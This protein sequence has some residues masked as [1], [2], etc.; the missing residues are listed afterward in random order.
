MELIA[1]DFEL[2]DCQSPIIGT[3]GTFD[4][5]H[6]GHQAILNRLVEA[7]QEMQ[8]KSLVI[9]FSPHPLQ[10]VRPDKAPKLLT[11]NGEKESVIAQCGIDY[12]LILPFDREMAQLGPEEFVRTV[13]I[14][15]CNMVKMIIG[16]D[17]GFGRNRSGHVDLLKKL[18]ETYNF[19]VSVVMPV[20]VGDFTVSSTNIR[21][22][23]QQGDLKLANTL[24][25]RPYVI[26]GKVV[27]GRKSGKRLGFPTANI[28]VDGT[29]KLIP[30]NGVYIIR[31][32]L[33]DNT[34]YGVMN[35]GNRPTLT[36]GQFAIE[37]HLFDFDGDIYDRYI[38]IETLE[39][40]R[41]ERRF[42]GVDTLKAQI[43][44]DINQAHAWLD[45][46]ISK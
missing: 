22:A 44:Q 31:A 2:A 1:Q 23:L 8:G 35:I 28:D 14:N 3:V 19:D 41:E 11:N 7:T 9:T 32:R 37:A 46:N 38:V 33:D 16:Y 20:R 43:Q 39:Y 40:I 12:L 45:A 30:K 5:V 26:S 13:L 4:G 18:G 29:K 25:G 17:H 36:P 6:Q 34:Y 10:V 21:E 42:G 27:V 15:R 24:L